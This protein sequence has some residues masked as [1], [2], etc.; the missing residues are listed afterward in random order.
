MD[1]KD[2]LIGDIRVTV[3]APKGPYNFKWVDEEDNIIALEK[4][5]QYDTVPSNV[6]KVL[7]QNNLTVIED[8]LESANTEIQ[9]ESSI[10][11]NNDFSTAG[12][13]ESEPTNE[14]NL[15]DDTNTAKEKKDESND[16][17]S[18]IV[19]MDNPDDR[20]KVVKKLKKSNVSASQK[21]QLT[22]PYKVY[23]EIKDNSLEIVG[24][25]D[26]GI[27]SETGKTN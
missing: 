5:C 22:G 9:N 24:I 7:K 27:G 1:K 13:I 8:D 17:I 21:L 15:L 10:S 25:E 16:Y 19:R 23:Y 2:V 3:L 20:E 4:N 14:S 6:E 18:F 12:L 11:N 26:M